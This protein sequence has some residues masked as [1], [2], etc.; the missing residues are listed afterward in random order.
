MNRLAR[1]SVEIN[2]RKCGANYRN[3]GIQSPRGERLH[4]H[5]SV[6]RRLLYLHLGCAQAPLEVL[7][8]Y[9]LLFGIRN[10]ADARESNLGTSTR[11]TA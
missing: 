6:N 1:A 10:P 5:R 9:S 2:R 11:D 4:E 3:S 7:R 8:I